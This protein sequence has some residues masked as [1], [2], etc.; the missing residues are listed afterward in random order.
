MIDIDDPLVGR[1]EAEHRDLV[2]RAEEVQAELDRLAALDGREIAKEG[3]IKYV[4]AEHLLDT[5]RILEET[6]HPTGIAA[7]DE[8][9]EG[10]IPGCVI[11][12]FVGPPRSCKSAFALQLALDRARS[13]TNGHR[14]VIRGYVPDQGWLQPLQRLARTH[15]DI[16]KDAEAYQAFVA[17]FSG[18]LF[19]VDE[20]RSKVTVESFADDVIR[21][22]DSSVVIIDTAQTVAV[23]GD[24]ISPKAKVEAA[25]DAARRI[26][27][28]LRI[29]V[30]VLNHA[31]RSSFAS[32]KP[33]ERTQGL[34]AGKESSA[35]EHRTQVFIHM[36]KTDVAEYT[37]VACVIEK[38]LGPTGQRFQ[39]RLD[40]ATWRLHEIETSEEVVTERMNERNRLVDDEVFEILAALLRAGEKGLSKT[41]A[42]EHV[43]ATL[44]NAGR[45]VGQ[46]YARESVARLV[47]AKRFFAE[48]GP[49][50]AHMLILPKDL[51]AEREAMYGAA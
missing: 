6:R 38:A 47:A 24:G 30:F 46:P 40:P 8:A 50:G 45:K 36:Q 19:L 37:E 16:T 42:E 7:L 49:R 29:P 1:L 13:A 33:E 26:A 22:K 12:S 4:S 20:W 31:T 28:A 10:G 32:K 35:I 44:Q 41:R 9:T 3:D 39:L 34:A 5:L 14:G 51:R 17:E 11:V 48:P 25:Y 23:E 27:D 43:R 2:A 18:V 21:R 15:G